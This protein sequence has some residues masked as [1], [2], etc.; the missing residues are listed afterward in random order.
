MV[1]LP[2]LR[3]TNEMNQPSTSRIYR[4]LDAI[5]QLINV[6]VYNGEPNHSLSGDAYRFNRTKLQQRIDWLFERMPFGW[7]ESDHCRLAHEA[8]IERAFNL[9]KEVTKV[10]TMSNNKNGDQK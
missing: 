7:H 5:S 9:C 4:A 2:R 1:E 8:D 6:L 10:N 3:E